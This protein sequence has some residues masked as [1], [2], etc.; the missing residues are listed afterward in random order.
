MSQQQIVHFK[1]IKLLLIQLK[2]YG[3]NPTDWRIDRASKIGTNE[4]VLVNRS[5]R[6][7]QFVGNLGIK[8]GLLGWSNLSL[9]S[10]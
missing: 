9:V 8:N 3:L 10:L 7:F 2:S 5:D 1:L 6:Q 4:I